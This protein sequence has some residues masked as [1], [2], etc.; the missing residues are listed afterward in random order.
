MG[1]NWPSAPLMSLRAA[2][3]G[4]AV[5]CPTRRSNPPRAR[6]PSLPASC[7]PTQELAAGAA[8][9]RTDIRKVGLRPLSATTSANGA[10]LLPAHFMVY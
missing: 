6:E 5:R 4:I 7:S 1:V 10:L 2:R 3:R 9:P 8:R